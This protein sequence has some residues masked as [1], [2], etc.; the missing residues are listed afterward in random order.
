MNTMKNAEKLL[1]ETNEKRARM[2]KARLSLTEEVRQIMKRGQTEK[3]YWKAPVIDLMEALYYVYEE[4]E[5]TDEYGQPL[6]FLA[7]VR[8]CSK[9]LHVKLPANPYC[10]AQRGKQRKGVKHQNFMTRYLDSIRMS[11][12]ITSCGD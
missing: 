4:G 11:I 2:R 1:A 8:S 7:L 10:M 12:Y 3:L 6:S 9:L 5:L